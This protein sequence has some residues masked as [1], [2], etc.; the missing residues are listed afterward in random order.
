MMS[1]LLMGGLVS[2][3]NF[4]IHAVIT[5]LIVVATRHLAAVTDDLHLFA[6]VSALLLVT[7][8]VL[9][10]GHLSEIAV[11]SIYYDAAGIKLVGVNAFEMA[12]ENFTALG[13]GDEVPKGELRIIGPVTAL[14]GLL[15][16]GWSV[17]ITFEV[18]R[19][20]E[21]QIVKR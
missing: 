14:N 21:V 6:R 9:M 3:A 16:I 8:V 5:G 1:H 11:W 17:A 4:G 20:A 13:Y 18:M 19:M 2:L 7:M 12:F 15:L 10:I